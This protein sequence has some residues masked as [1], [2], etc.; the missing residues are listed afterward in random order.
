MVARERVCKPV[1]P[2]SGE[3]SVIGVPLRIRVCKLVS[4]A[5]SG[6]RRPRALKSAP[7]NFSVCVPLLAAS[8]IRAYTFA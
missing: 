5:I 2:N 1:K 8:A 4:F 7:I 6:G 3:R